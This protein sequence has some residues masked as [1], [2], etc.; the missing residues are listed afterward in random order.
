M[1]E[2]GG[3]PANNGR[4]KAPQVQVNVQS[5][6][7]AAANSQA[8]A[9]VQQTVAQAAVQT[10]PTTIVQASPVQESKA[11]SLR[12]TRQDAEV[13]TEQKIV[14]KLEESRL[15]DEQRRSEVLFGDKFNQLQNNSV[16]VA[17]S[18][19]AVVSTQQQQP[20]AVA[21]QA[22]TPVAPVAQLA[23]PPVVE[24]APAPVVKQEVDK[25][26]VRN[27]VRLSLEE[28]KE[29]EKEGDEKKTHQTYVSAL[30]GMGDY[31]D[32]QNIRGKYA[33]GLAIGQK[34]NDRLLWEGS[35]I[36][37]QYD[38][39]QRD[40]YQD[41]FGNFYHR[42]TQMNQY[43][44][45]GLIK[46]QVLGGTFRPVIGGVLGYTYRNYKDTQFAYTNNQATSQALDAGVMAG[47]DLEVSEGFSIGLDV[48]YMWNLTSQVSNQGL[49]RSFSQNTYGSDTPVESL[50][51]MTIGLVGR[52]T[53]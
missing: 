15:K 22:V 43:A 4:A 21:Q 19:G 40:G 48:R 52:A 37:S 23:P 8:L 1:Y 28:M 31:P 39:E 51:Y 45:Q 2:Q 18:P 41:A 14:E 50:S 46:Y 47:A 34:I 27:E 49:Q 42:I 5:S 7:A 33:A 17:G 35:F 6:P 3:A 12:K 44:G 11:E 25:E 20:I 26:G 9:P 10:Q 16:I 29:K 38:V 36:Y 53:F 13:Q 30:V 32:V 24:V